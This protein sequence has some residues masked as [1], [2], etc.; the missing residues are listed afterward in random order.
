MAQL[1]LIVASLA[2]LVSGV[3]APAV[4][5]QPAPGDST[6]FAAREAVWRDYFAA[7]PDL[8]ATL[9]DDFVAL[10]AGDSSWDG[11]ARILARAEAS[12]R[13]GTRLSSLRFPRNVVQRHGNVA[14]IHSR[15]E[16]VLER[17]GKPM[18]MKGQI[19]E[20]FVWD[21]KRWL[22]PSWHMDFD[23]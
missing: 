22:H 9:P 13:S 6:L 20:V 8:K 3:V 5:Q 2:A 12:V 4:A 15:Y 17:E 19:T 11:K 16:A 7:S 14:V 10:Q 18:T 23:S 21:G 1:S